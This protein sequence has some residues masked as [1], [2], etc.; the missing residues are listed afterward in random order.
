MNNILISV[1]SLANKNN[2]FFKSEKQAQFLISELV[3]AD[4]HFIEWFEFGYTGKEKHSRSVFVSYDDQGITEIKTKATISGKENIK[5][6][7]K[8]EQ[9]QA[10]WLAARNAKWNAEFL[11]LIEAFTENMSVEQAKI[12][13]VT[14]EYT[15]M[16]E[17]ARNA[18]IEQ[19]RSDEVPSL[20]Q[21]FERLI[22]VST[23]DFKKQVEHWK[24]SIEDMRSR[25]K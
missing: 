11:G 19:N 5:F 23:A 3:K 2:G 15:A 12:D 4:C 20:E 17:K 7:R 6:K 14:A 1:Y 21:N 16:L 10:E 24:N 13:K 8:T 25:L 22:E 18:M 9:E